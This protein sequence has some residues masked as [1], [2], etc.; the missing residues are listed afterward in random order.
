MPDCVLMMPT[1][2]NVIIV[3]AISVA[4]VSITFSQ[5][6]IRG[7]RRAH[8]RQVIQEFTQLLAIPNVASD[9]EN[10]RRN[11]E[12][13]LEMMSRRGLNPRLLE[14]KST[15][16]PPAVLGNGK[17]PALLTRSSCTRTTTVSLL[18]QNSGQAL[19]RGNRRGA[20]R[21]SRLADKS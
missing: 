6:E 8:E 12:F 21:R 18:I 3:S 1:V 10:I 15:A 19:C 9:R 16:T 4:S 5:T 17:Y 2:R 11:A 7:Y 13:I 20:R 14:A